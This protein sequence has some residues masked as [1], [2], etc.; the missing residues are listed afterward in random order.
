MKPFFN[1]FVESLVFKDSDTGKFT[2]FNKVDEACG[3]GKSYYE[4]SSTPNIG[5]NQIK[6]PM[7]MYI[8]GKLF[9][10]FTAHF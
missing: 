7:G 3:D 4:K 5:A 6:N 9:D 10:M 1:I 2:Y 8:I